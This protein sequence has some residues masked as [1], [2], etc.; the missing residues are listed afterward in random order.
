MHNHKIILTELFNGLFWKRKTGNFVEISI[1]DHIYT[2]YKR[3]SQIR[4]RSILNECY[5]Y[6]NYILKTKQS[7]TFDVPKW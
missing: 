2:K 3:R 4:E 7:Q 6:R 1:S 5:L